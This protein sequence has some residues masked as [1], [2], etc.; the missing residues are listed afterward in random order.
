MKLYILRHGE[1]EWNKN[2]LFQGQRDVPLNDFGREL[3]VITREAAPRI[4]YDRV[5]SSPLSRALE[6]AQIFV[7]DNFPVDQISIDDRLIE[8]GFGDY[9]GCDIEAASKD[10]SHPVYDCLWH[11]ENYVPQNGAESFEHL[12]SRAKD[13][14]QNEIIP[15][16]NQCKNVLVVAHG[17][18]IRA[19]VSAVGK[20]KIADF[21]G[22]QYFNCC[23]TTM[24]VTNGNITLEK[25]AEIFYDPHLLKHPGWKK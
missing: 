15:L 12:V 23:I 6:T 22:T 18:L 13:F 5:Y 24:D 3:A 14:L 11:P 8:I 7:K 10:P 17:A 1:T 19:L 16:E 9:E 20:K 4:H 21:W 2:H 25:E